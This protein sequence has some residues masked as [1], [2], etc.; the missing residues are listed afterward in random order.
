[1]KLYQLVSSKT[2]ERVVRRSDESQSEAWNWVIDCSL[3]VLPFVGLKNPL[4][5]SFGTS[6]SLSHLYPDLYVCGKLVLIIR[7][8]FMK[9]CMKYGGL[10]RRTA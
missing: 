4:L 2:L 3:R 8:G 5:S 1:M 7:P 10:Y 9:V 6:E